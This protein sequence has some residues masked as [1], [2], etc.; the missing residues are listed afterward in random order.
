MLLAFVLW[1]GCSSDSGV[2]SVADAN[3]GGAI[4]SPDTSLNPDG[5][6]DV[7][8]L[9]DGVISDEEVTDDDA[10]AACAPVCEG[11]E[12]GDDGCGGSCGLCEEGWFCDAG[13]C[14]EECV[15]DEACEE[16][17]VQICAEDGL[18]V[19]ICEEAQ[20]GCL[21]LSQPEACADGELCL[22]GV[23]MTPC[24]P[25]CVGKACGDDGCGGSCG[26][27]CD[28]DN[29]CTDDACAATG[30]CSY[31]PNAESCDDGDACTG[32]DLCMMG[33]C[34]AGPQ[35]SCDDENECTVD[36]CD[37]VTGCLNPAAEDGI[38]CDDE[39]A[40]TEGEI[41][42][43]GGCTA[44]DPV[45]CDDDDACTTDICDITDGCITEEAYPGCELPEVTC[46]DA[47]DNDQDGATDCAD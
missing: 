3:D 30:Q 33:A 39:D 19:L 22:D 40:C 17:G 2:I 7:P 20:P 14:T 21:R 25:D 42:F 45:V 41:C 16:A 32:A 37:P 23:C 38:A 9:G 34:T 18:G 44:G 24:V 11:L 8:E 46:D 47:L 31:T 27:A 10:D 1:A 35:L 12:C 29:P 26:P 28:D 15:S 5:V 43:A 6:T 13:A 36:S 4:G